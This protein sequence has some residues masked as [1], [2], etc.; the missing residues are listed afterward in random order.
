M[1]VAPN[2]RYVNRKHY[3]LSDIPYNYAV[4]NLAAP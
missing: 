1:D 2:E 3:A 4:G